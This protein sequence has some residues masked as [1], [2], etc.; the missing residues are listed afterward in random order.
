[1]EKSVLNQEPCTSFFLIGFMASGKSSYGRK[2][3]KRLALPFIDLDSAIEEAVGMSIPEL[4]QKQGEEAFRTTERETLKRLLP[5]PGII[6]LGGG[7]VCSEGIWPLLKA[8]GITVF[9]DMPFEQ[10]LGR[11]RTSKKARPLAENLE[12]KTAIE[13]LRALYEKRRAIYKLADHKISFPYDHSVVAT[14]LSS[15]MK[16]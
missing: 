16:A 10:C 14:K 15:W 12:D 8:N 13:K 2:A 1:M 3:A 11:L 5:H 6:S 9:L 7:T 4:F